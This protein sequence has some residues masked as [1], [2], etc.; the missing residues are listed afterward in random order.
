MSKSQGLQ[1]R[2]ECMHEWEIVG[3]GARAG[4]GSGERS[5]YAL[6]F[7]FVLYSLD[8]GDSGVA[9][10]R[11]LWSARQERS[12]EQ[13]ARIWTACGGAQTRRSL[14]RRRFLKELFRLPCG[15]SASVTISRFFIRRSVSSTFIGIPRSSI[16]LGGESAVD[17]YTL[18]ADE[19]YT[20]ASD[21]GVTGSLGRFWTFEFWAA[22]GNAMHWF[23]RLHLSTAFCSS[24]VELTDVMGVHIRGD[25]I[26]EK[27]S[28]FLGSCH[29]HTEV[30]FRRWCRVMEK[31]PTDRSV[32]LMRS[33]YIDAPKYTGD[34]EICGPQNGQ[35]WSKTAET[36]Q[37]APKCTKVAIL[38]ATYLAI[39]LRDGREHPEL[40]SD[41]LGLCPKKLLLKWKQLIFRFIPYSA[42]NDGASIYF[43]LISSTE[44]RGFRTNPAAK[45]DLGVSA[46]TAEKFRKLLSDGI[47][48]DVNTHHIR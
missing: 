21:G 25:S 22:G 12:K 11:I 15:G 45:Q 30:L 10:G 46:T 40:Q 44:R 28:E 24:E 3:D 43:D 39:P 41:N 20:L 37:N 36:S 4:G 1:H 14:G 29:T 23:S 19:W 38:R 47:A 16:K 26:A 35:K 2:L 48:A 31:D 27:F 32:L 42:P 33:K 9:E 17:L 13:G 8:F 34:S 6:L 18:G 7:S 5:G